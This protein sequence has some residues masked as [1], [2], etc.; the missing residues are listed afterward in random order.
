MPR[1]KQA[2]PNRAACWSPTMALIGTPASGEPAPEGGV[3]R[4]C[5][6]GRTRAAPR[7]GRR[8]G[9]PNRSQSSVGPAPDHDVEE[10]GARG[11]GD[12]G[13]EHARRRCPRSGSTGSTSRRWPRARSGTGR[14]AAL[15]RAATASWWPRSRGRG[16]GRSAPGPGGGGRPRPARRSGRPSGGP[17]RRGPGG[18]GAPVR[19]S[20]A[21][22]V[23]RWLVM[24]D[25]PGH[26][27]GV[28]QAAG[29]LVQG[30]AHQAPDLVGVV[31][32]PAG[33]GEVLGQLPV[34][35]VDHPGPLVDDQG[36]DAGGAGV[37]GDADGG[38]GRPQRGL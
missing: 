11:V 35:D 30:V 36:P 9:T 4:P 32:D 6:T 19:R 37:D 16:P 33:P 15:G 29:H 3:G 1:S 12:V 17:A 14:D 27:A 25:G 2:W 20:Q 5:R 38:A 26:P 28:G 23:S 31:L 10:H 24:P 22:T 34:G 21:T 8:A 18:A 7:P 13:G